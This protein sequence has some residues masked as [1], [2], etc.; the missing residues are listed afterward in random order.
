MLW[1]SSGYF[2]ITPMYTGGSMAKNNQTDDSDARLEAALYKLADN[3]A[4]LASTGYYN[5]KEIKGDIA[6]ILAAVASSRVE[7]QTV[8][9]KKVEFR[10]T[11]VNRDMHLFIDGFHNPK[12]CPECIHPGLLQPP[13]K[14]PLPPFDEWYAKTKAYGG[15]REEYDKLVA[16]NTPVRQVIRP[17]IIMEVPAHWDATHFRATTAAGRKFVYCPVGNI[18]SWSV[19]DYDHHYC[20]WCKSFFGDLEQAAA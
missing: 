4:G 9:G 12:V 1:K 2:T 14:E 11:A 10:H 20:P 18:C 19:G 13:T 5:H 16:G 3:A 7:W 15:T 6:A 8:A 17:A